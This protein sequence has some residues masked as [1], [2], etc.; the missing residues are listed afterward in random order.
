[1]SQIRRRDMKVAI[2]Y[3]STTGNTKV[4]ALYAQKKMQKM[5]HQCEIWDI[6]KKEIP[7]DD[8]D[9]IG[10]ASPTLYFRGSFTMDRILTHLSPVGEEKKKRAFLFASCAGEPGAQF[11]TQ[12]KILRNKGYL[13]LGAHWVMAPSNWP[14]QRALTDKI[15]WST[16]VGK[17][18]ASKFRPLKGLLAF[19]WPDLGTPDIKDREGFDTFLT[20]MVNMALSD[21]IEIPSINSLHKGF[22]G[23]VASGMK[24]TLEK[25]GKAAR[26]HIN[27][28]TCIDCDICIKSC[29]ERVIMK[30]SPSEKPV[31]GAGCAGCFTCYHLCPKGAIHSFTTKGGSGK[32]HGPSEEFRAIFTLDEL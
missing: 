7:L 9:L 22:P 29:P 25:A 10:V 32:Y 3:H 30:A 19:L 23:A 31:V 5:G 15:S 24:I 11:Q 14:L 13:T 2:L 20:Q 26:I 12:A 28:D 17:A 16:P 21:E 4:I 6:T 8:I 18:V 1:M 27:P